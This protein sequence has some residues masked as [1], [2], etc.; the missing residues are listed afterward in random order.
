MPF[1]HF[2]DWIHVFPKGHDMY[3]YC[4]AVTLFSSLHKP[5]PTNRRSNNT[6]VVRFVQKAAGVAAGQVT[7]IAIGAAAAEGPRNDPAEETRSLC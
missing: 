3:L 4:A 1:Q 5:I 7:F 6:P 2:N